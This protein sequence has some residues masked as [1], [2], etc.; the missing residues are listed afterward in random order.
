MPL[1]KKLWST[2]FVFITAGISGFS[3]TLLALL[4]DVLGT[5]LNQYSRIVN[6]ITKPFVWLGRNPLIIFIL[7]DGLA[8]VLI[9]YIIIEDKSAWG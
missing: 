2:S 9:K 8:I 6:F 3:L 1:N 5:K 4:V 7:M